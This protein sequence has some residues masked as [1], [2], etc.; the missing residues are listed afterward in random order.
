MANRTLFLLV[1]LLPALV[2][3]LVQGAHQGC[4]QKLAKYCKGWNTESV[5]KCLAC[6]KAEL[7][8]LEPNCTLA[9]ATNKCN[10]PPPSPGPP[11]TPE[12]PLPPWTPITPKAGAPRPHIVLWVVDDLGYANVGYRNPENVKTPNTDR[13]AEEGLVLDRHYT[14]RW[15]APTRSAL[16]TGRLPYHVL[17]TTDH[18]DRGFSMI[19]AKLRQVG[20][21]PHQI[22]K[23]IICFSI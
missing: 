19:P 2:P 4:Q 16:M 1:A 13:Y 14:F 20:Y 3:A 12:P 6:V 17:Q 23:V 5:A 8:K 15:C 9:L 11:P 22:G 7:P 21:R 10:H 18:V